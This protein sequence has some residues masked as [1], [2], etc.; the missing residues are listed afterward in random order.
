M[1]QPLTGSPVP[2]HSS[3]DWFT[4]KAA[5][6]AGKYFLI[7]IFIKKWWK[8][9]TSQVTKSPSE[10]QKSGRDQKQAGLFF[11][12]TYQHHLGE[13]WNLFTTILGEVWAG[14]TI[15]RRW[16]NLFWKSDFSPKKHRLRERWSTDSLISIKAD[17]ILNAPES[18]YRNTAREQSTPS[19]RNT[20]SYGLRR[21]VQ[22][23]EISGLK[24]LNHFLSGQSPTS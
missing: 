12:W 7:F 6:G 16:G 5:T 8:K 23:L 20:C 14:N 10:N 2:P 11:I 4:S 9:E 24:S 18:Q 1:C 13:I 22:S 17:P 19:F 21:S 15:K 3:A